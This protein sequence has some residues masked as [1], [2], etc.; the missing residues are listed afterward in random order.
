MDCCAPP[1][2]SPTGR[3]F[4]PACCILCP[5]HASPPRGAASGEPAPLQK[6]HG[7]AL[8]SLPCSATS[9]LR[10]LQGSHPLPSLQSLRAYRAQ[11][12]VTFQATASRSQAR[13]SHSQARPYIGCSP[14]P[15]AI[16]AGRDFL[17]RRRCR[18]SH[19]GPS[20]SSTPTRD[21]PRLCWHWGAGRSPGGGL[22]H[23]PVLLRHGPRHARLGADCCHRLVR[24]LAAAP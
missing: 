3:A 10:R 14:S 7:G 13:P 16:F 21:G 23:H 17:G 24:Q 11:V 22:L 6:A 20:S 4:K 5:S 9:P 15:I 18:S 19:A 2:P 1:A 12:P 8:L